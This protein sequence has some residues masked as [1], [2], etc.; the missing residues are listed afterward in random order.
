VKK[1]IL[2]TGGLGYVGG[3][4]V[5]SL[6]NDYDIVVSSRRDFSLS[7]LDLPNNIS[8]VNHHFLINN[9]SFP[10]EVDT[11]IHLAALNE[12]DCVKFPQQAVEV[13]INQTR[14]LIQTAIA[15]GVKRFIYFSTIHVYGHVKN[16]TVVTEESLTRPVH[17]YSI[18]HRAAEDYV[19]QAHDSGLVDGIVVRLS[20]S[21]GSPLFPSV[22]RWSLLVN[23]ICKQAVTKSEIK[24]MSNG[25]QYRDFITLS[26]VVAAVR[27]LVAAKKMQSPNIFNL[28]SEVST[29]VFDMANKVANCC[30]EMFG[31]AIPV[32]VPP[33]SQ[34]TQE[35]HYIIKSN[36]FSLLG[37]KPQNNFQQELLE[38]LQFCKLHFGTA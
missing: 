21:F 5:K 26:D 4:L 14:E 6:S 37:V 28:S 20:N 25:C 32:L 11:V 8:Q 27:F 34:P 9:K 18:T 22:N 31:K 16:G 36:N 30:E 33:D 7:G 23:D 12:I 24:L 1:N 10:K 35:A 19:N 17:P 3:R 13:N 29:T 2:I 15:N 38:L